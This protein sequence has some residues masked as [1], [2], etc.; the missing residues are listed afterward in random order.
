MLM[1]PCQG[2][3]HFFVKNRVITML[4][5]DEQNMPGLDPV[6]R[7]AFDYWP[8][9]VVGNGPVGMHLIQELSRL[10]FPERILIYGKEPYA[11]YNRIWLSSLLNGELSPHELICDWQRPET[12]TERLGCEVTL[13]DTRNHLLTDSTGERIRYGKLVLATG[14]TAHIPSI[15]GIDKP[16]VFSFRNY[17]DAQELFVRRLSSRHTVVLGGGLL[18]LEAAR[19]MLHHS[20]RVTVIHHS[21]TLMNRQ[22][23]ERASNEL[24]AHLESL[25]IHIRLNTAVTQVWGRERV[26]GLQLRFGEA[27]SCDTL[28]VATGI[29]PAIEVARQAG[30]AVGQGVRVNEH[31]QTSVPDVY[32]IGECAEY[33]GAI[34]GLVG[35]GLEQAGVLAR[36]L[37]ED[38]QAQYRGSLSVT[39]LKVTGLPVFSVGQTTEAELQSHINRLCWEDG[40]HYRS[41]VL[42]RGRIIGAV[43]TGEWAD[44]PAI[45]SLVEQKRFIWPWQRWRFLSQ[46][47][48]TA[49]EE[50]GLAGQPDSTII[51]NCRQIPLGQLREAHQQGADSVQALREATSAS[52]VCGSCEPLLAQLVE[53]TPAN[54]A[55]GPWRHLAAA[56]FLALVLTALL[57]LLPPLPVPDSVHSVGLSPWWLDNSLRQWSGYATLALIVLGLALS[58]RKRVERFKWGSFKLW[59]GIHVFISALAILVLMLHTGLDTGHHFNAFLYINVLAL[60]ALGGFAALLSAYEVHSATLAAKRWKRRISGLHLYLVWPVPVLLGFHILVLYYFGGG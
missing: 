44:F 21:A 12:I 17:Q 30:V 18:G 57:P 60:I 11:P 40:E 26:E 38:S 23:D 15:P 59:R 32:A 50:R 48:I 24:Q 49:P 33:A 28:V 47:Q 5:T 37:Q 20:T 54:T 35:P 4:D 13:I 2:H 1:L 19:S 8:L 25:G 31:L 39:K 3:G 43:G 41:L 7:E 42:D 56:G 22:L 51:C 46:G 14:S 16:G 29:R 34:Y 53:E 36:H 58:P 9:V 10:G 55:R 27:L 45:Q 52:T 6:T